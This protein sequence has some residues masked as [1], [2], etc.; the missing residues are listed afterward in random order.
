MTNVDTF[1]AKKIK[2]GSVVAIIG[3]TGKGKTHLVKDLVSNM[4][5]PVDYGFVVTNQDA[6]CDSYKDVFPS[7]RHCS[8]FDASMLDEI[9]N[10]QKRGKN[11]ARVLNL[12]V[13]TVKHVCI[14]IDDLSEENVKTSC[15]FEMFLNGRHLNLT[16]VF[17][18]QYPLPM[19]ANMR[20]NI[21]Y[22]F[23]SGNQLTSDP[24]QLKLLHKYFGCLPD[25]FQLQNLLSVVGMKRYNFLVDDNT[26]S[27]RGK[28]T[29]FQY[30]A[31]ADVS[32]SNKTT[33]KKWIASKM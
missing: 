13:S 5:D 2:S 30:K 4:A 19:A 14:V 21:D 31:D 22:V 7:F 9:I 10:M 20:I 17:T 18:S 27:T 12:P 32:R 28:S 23:V 24:D 15:L 6:E 3:R 25:H 11:E 33:K 16:V 29:I 1:N 8:A 26:I